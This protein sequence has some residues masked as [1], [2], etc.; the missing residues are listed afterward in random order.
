MAYKVLRLLEY[1][2]V[3]VEQA[4]T[5]MGHWM[6]PANGIVSQGFKKGQVVRSTIIQYP[7]ADDETV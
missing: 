4:D 7:E 1:T 3:D 5:D 2:Y 6:V